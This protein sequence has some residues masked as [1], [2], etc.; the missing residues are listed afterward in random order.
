MDSEDGHDYAQIISLLH[1]TNL[2]IDKFKNVTTPFQQQQHITFSFFDASIY[3]LQHLT[4]CEWVLL[5]TGSES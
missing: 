4:Q 5:V 3:N 2:S 1:L